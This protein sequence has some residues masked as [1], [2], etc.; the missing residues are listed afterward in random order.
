M[1]APTKPRKPRLQSDRSP[2]TKSNGAPQGKAPQS[3]RTHAPPW[4]SGASAPRPAL[5]KGTGLQPLWM[6]RRK[7]CC[8]PKPPRTGGAT[9]SSPESLE[10]TRSGR[11]RPQSR[12][13]PSKNAIE[14]DTTALTRRKSNHLKPTH[15]RGRAALQRRVKPSKKNG[16]QPLWMARRKDCCLPKPP[17]TGGATDSSPESLKATRSGRTRPQSRLKPSKNAIEPATTAL[18]RRKSNHLKPTQHRGRAALQRRVTPSKRN[19]ASAPG[20]GSSEGL[21]SADATTNRGCP[22]LRALCEGWDSADVSL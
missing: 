10:A 22:I 7:D 18:T 1:V 11:T 14:P 20:D 15:H 6:A 21:L 16:L 12:L 2:R 4:K 8:P 13:K 9:D 5:E 17:R 19:R 3:P